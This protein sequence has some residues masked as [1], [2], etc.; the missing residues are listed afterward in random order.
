MFQICWFLNFLQQGKERI[1]RASDRKLS[2]VFTRKE[3]CHTKDWKIKTGGEERPRGNL[4]QGQGG[5]EHQDKTESVTGSQFRCKN[6]T[7]VS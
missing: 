7:W 4:E 2:C 3:Q 6:S 5:D 1:Y